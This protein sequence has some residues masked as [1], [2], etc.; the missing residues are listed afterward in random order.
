MLYSFLH[1]RTPIHSQGFMGN[2]DDMSTPCPSI[3]L[4]IPLFNEEENVRPIYEA[5]VGVLQNLEIT[6]ELIL[7][8]DGSTDATGDLIDEIAEQDPRVLPLHFRSNFGQT[9][10][11]QAGIEHSRGGVIIPLDGDMQND[12]SDIPRLLEKLD[13]GYDVVS[14]WRKTRHDK[15]FTRKLP[16]AAANWLISVVSGVHL[17][18]YGCTLKAYRRDVLEDVKLYGEMHRFIPI[19]CAWQGGR[20]TELPVAHHPRTRGKSKYGLR[21]IFKVVLDL[22]LV[23]FMAAYRTKPL[24]FFG[25]LGLLS[26]LLAFPVTAYALWLKFVEHLSLNR[27]PLPLLAVLCVILGV[28]FIMMGILAEIIIR[29]YYESQ[30]KKPYILRKPRKPPEA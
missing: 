4:V 6:A 30:D 10:A 14:G 25:G 3:S 23:R 26:I 29:V 20:V 28:Q 1:E 9:A 24:H 13:E 11:M 12:P 21:R 22:I 18:D 5:I 19:Y 8:N 7:V 2:A 17:H 15:L 27:T 16:S